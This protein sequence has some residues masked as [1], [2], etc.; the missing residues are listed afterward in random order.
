MLSIALLNRLKDTV[1]LKLREE[2]TSFRR[3]RSYFEQIFT[4]RN[5]IEQCIEFQNTLVLNFFDFKKAFDSIHRESL[6]KILALYG[7]PQKYIT[8]IYMNSSCCVKTENG[9]SLFFAIVTGARQGCILSPFLFLI[10]VDFILHKTMEGSRFGIKRL[11]QS[12]FADLD[13]ADDYIALVESD[14]DKL[15]ELTHKLYV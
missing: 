8:I 4:L 1:D 15:N 14:M 11:D 6:W 13:F 5:I 2:Q 9:F 10:V 3:G 7:I 12:R